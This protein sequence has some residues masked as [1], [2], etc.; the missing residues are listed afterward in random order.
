MGQTNQMVGGLADV[1]AE[2]ALERIAINKVEVLSNRLVPGSDSCIEHVVVGNNGVTVIRSVTL[3]GRLR[4][5]R[6]DVL[7]GG[8]SAKVVVAGLEARINTVRHLVGG[9]MRVQG[10]IFLP[11]NKKA[12]VKEFESIAIGSPKAVVQHLI[13]QHC[14]AAPAAN[15]TSVTHQLDGMFLPYEKVSGVAPAA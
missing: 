9:D 8:V 2:N 11:K 1:A 14:E 10:A 7:V 6:S 5:T 15:L 13:A 3:K 12:P 4:I